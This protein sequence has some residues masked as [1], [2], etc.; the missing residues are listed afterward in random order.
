LSFGD[1]DGEH[2]KR[3]QEG[4]SFGAHENISRSQKNLNCRLGEPCACRKRRAPFCG[5][6]KGKTLALTRDMMSAMTR[7]STES[8]SQVAS[9]VHQTPEREAT[10][11]N[12]FQLL[13]DRQTN[14]RRSSA[15]A[16]RWR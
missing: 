12:F 16:S 5:L 14:W 13:I 6:K 2:E 11:Q 8:A 7:G 15:S 1:A 9:G 3:Q 10:S 4:E